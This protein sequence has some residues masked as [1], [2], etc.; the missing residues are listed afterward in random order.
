M[1]RYRVGNKFLS[2]SEYREE[3]LGVW[4]FF[5]FVIGCVLAGI[6]SNQLMLEVDLPKWARFSIVI[7]CSLLFG[8]LLAK[9]AELIRNMFYICLFGGVLFFIGTLVWDVV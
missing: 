7:F 9:F 1:A 5:L 2:E 6:I 4:A 3:T 8:Y